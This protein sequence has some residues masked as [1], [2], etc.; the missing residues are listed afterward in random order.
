MIDRLHCALLR[1]W[2][3]DDQPVGV[4]FL[5]GA[6]YALTAAHVAARAVG[7]GDDSTTPPGV[8][9]SVDFP[10]VEPG[11]RHRARVVVWRPVAPDGVGDIAGLELLDPLPKGSSA[12]PLSTRGSVVNRQVAVFGVPRVADGGVWSIGRLRGPQSHGWLQIDTQ[13]DSQFA[14][15]EGFSGA[16]VWDIEREAVQGMVVTAHLGGRIQTGYMLPSAA[17]IDGWPDLGAMVWPPSPYPGLRAFEEADADVFHG[18]SALA[19]RVRKLTQ[20]APV[21]TVLGPSGAGKSSLIKAGVLPVLR[22][23]DDVLVAALRPSEASTPVGALALALDRLLVPQR[24][25]LR[26]LDA[27]RSLAGELSQGGIATIVSEIVHRHDGRDLLVFID[28]L[29]EAFAADQEQVAAF[30]SV[31]RHCLEPAARMRLLLALRADHLG[32]ALHQPAVA[33]LVDDRRTVM[34]GELNFEEMREAITAP[35]ADLHTVIFEP[36]LVDR[37]LDDVG[38]APGRLPLLQFALRELW[39]NQR[40]GM[41]THQAYEQIG[42]VDHALASRAEQVWDALAPGEQTTARRLL[43]QLLRPDPDSPTFSS[44]A[45]TNDELDAAQWS[46]AQRLV[47]ARLLVA[48]DVNRL[49]STDGAAIAGVELAHE[50]LAT[51]WTR[52]HEFQHEQRDF[53]LWQEALR[54]RITR[55]REDDRHR[56]RLLTGA[57]LR[58]ALRWLRS[59]RADLPPAEHS[60]I[61]ASRKR[62][63]RLVRWTSSAVAILLI[64][65]LVTGGIVVRLRQ[66]AD[67]EH[68]LVLSRQLAA[69]AVQVV[70]DPARAAMLAIGAWQASPTQEAHNALIAAQGGDVLATGGKYGSPPPFAAFQPNGNLVATTGDDLAAGN[71]ELVSHQSTITM[72]DRTLTGDTLSSEPAW[73]RMSTSGKQWDSAFE[74][75]LARFSHDGDKMVWA[76]PAD[77]SVR[78]L[79]ADTGEVLATYHHGCVLRNINYSVS[80]DHVFVDVDECDSD[81]TL[82]PQRFVLDAS[83]LD[84]VAVKETPPS[85]EVPSWQKVV[86]FPLG[87][88]S[89]DGRTAAW[90]DNA[91]AAASHQ[92]TM[93]TTDSSKYL[94]LV[95]LDLRKV[96]ATVGNDGQIIRTIVFSPNGALLATAGEDNTLRLWDVTDPKSPRRFLQF[97]AQEQLSDAVI[98][99][100]GSFIVTIGTTGDALLWRTNPDHA[101]RTLCGRLDSRTLSDTWRSLGPDHGDPPRC[102]A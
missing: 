61:T 91:E 23:R 80:G 83:N 99:E 78:L 15:Q 101:I 72:H 94:H 12:A 16:P 19:A 59:H 82:A 65:A 26:R 92:A 90:T 40:A 8:P 45:A 67:A 38:M 53:R 79:K 69:E 97:K 42:R 49:D 7:L 13:P 102:P 52:L 32:A 55:W 58:D 76:T 5:V 87:A 68:R 21:I 54:R 88:T 75:S 98:S 4:G 3:L 96:L 10:L 41:L 22:A 17:L 37:I 43:V 33:L 100:D 11:L 71:A 30:G 25:P 57:D 62:R 6:R 31:L 48:R 86:T 27:A 44:R 39:S 18:R 85:N 81:G 36:G 9:L 89:P 73:V 63:N 66:Q 70:A 64:A 29:E 14:I 95:D 1:V 56:R 47:T 24:D 74:S 77:E 46:I 50:A 2:G 35:I 20:H 60:F 93:G 51:H 34:V 84:R 28:Q